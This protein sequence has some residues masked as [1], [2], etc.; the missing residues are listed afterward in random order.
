MISS[1]PGRDPRPAP[2]CRRGI[3]CIGRR[4]RT[5]GGRSPRCHILSSSRTA[6]N[7]SRHSPRIPGRLRRIA[8]ENSDFV[9]EIVALRALREPLKALVKRQVVRVAVLSQEFA[10]FRRA[11]PRRKQ[12]RAVD[13]YQRTSRAGALLAEYLYL[14]SPR[15]GAAVESARVSAYVELAARQRKRLA[16]FIPSRDGAV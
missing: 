12:L 15:G 3:P 4:L 16:H 2:A 13:K 1:A 11:E 8:K 9:R 5:S 10:V 14:Q 7:C 6:C